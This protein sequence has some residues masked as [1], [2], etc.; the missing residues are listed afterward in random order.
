MPQPETVT[1]LPIKSSDSLVGRQIGRIFMVEPKSISVANL[2]ICH[3]HSVVLNSVSILR[4]DVY[5]GYAKGEGV[6]LCIS[7]PVVLSQQHSD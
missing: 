7:P 1:V 4:V 6:S 5:L 2:P 3:V